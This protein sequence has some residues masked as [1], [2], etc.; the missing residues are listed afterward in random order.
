MHALSTGECGDGIDHLL[1]AVCLMAAT[2][3]WSSHQLI[4]LWLCATKRDF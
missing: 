1:I 2:M 4:T 3:F